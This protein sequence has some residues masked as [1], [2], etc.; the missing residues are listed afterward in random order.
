VYLA[1]NSPKIHS[2]VV[3]G[4]SSNWQL[5]LQAVD[6]RLKTRYADMFTFNII[7]IALLVTVYSAGQAWGHFCLVD[8]PARL[9]PSGPYSIM[10][11]ATTRRVG[12]NETSSSNCDGGL[13]FGCRNPKLNRDKSVCG[14]PFYVRT[15]HFSIACSPTS[16]SHQI[17]LC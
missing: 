15:R 9:A 16:N 7:W 12:I 17:E 6:T 2:V 3:P 13:G 4:F 8:P 14:G 10:C 1:R 5:C 11:D